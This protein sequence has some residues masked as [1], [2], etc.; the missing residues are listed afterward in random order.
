LNVF[1]EEDGGFKVGTILADNN[2]SL[3]VEAPHGKRSKVKANAV[4]LRF[5]R[6]APAEFLHCAQAV[7]DEVDAGFLWEVAPQAEFDYGTLARDY[8]GREPSPVEAAGLLM[9]LHGSPMHFYKKGKGCYRA[10]PAEALK[11]ALASVERKRQQAATQAAYVEA[12]TRFELPDAFRPRLAELLYEPDRNSVEFKALDAASAATGLSPVHLLD[13]CGAIASSHDY[14]LGRFLREH[15]P[16]GT[17][18]GDGLAWVEPED[19][20]VADV[21]AFSI[22]DATTTEIDDALSVRPLPSGGWRVGIHIAAPALGIPRGGDLDRVAF[23]R[24]S[25]VYMPGRKITMLPDSV[26]D[27]FTLREG[28]DCPVVSLYVYLDDGLAP[29][30]YET[31]I[32]RVPVRANL[33]HD[34]LEA[35]FNEATLASGSLDFPF[36]PELK[37]LWSFALRVEAARGKAPGGVER[38]DYNFYVEGDRVRIV[39]RR[40]GSPVDKLVAEL[41]ILANTRWGRELADANRGGIYRAQSNGRVRMSLVPAP[42]EGLGVEQY[43]WSTSPLRRYVDLVNQ[44]QIVAMA[45]NEPPPYARAG[46]DIAVAMRNFE[47]AYDAYAE[48]QRTMERYWCLRWVVQESAWRQPATVLRES[49]VRLDRIPL[50]ARVPSLPELAP[51]TPVDV[52][53]SNVDLLSIDVDC[54]FVGR[55]ESLAAAAA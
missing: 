11:A 2:T 19:L 39:E 42:H 41:M 45:R 15:F 4:M 7:A 36:G 47:V 30:A 5:E 25:T 52:E 28:R 20:S 17:G 3:Q 9:R 34:V 29:G 27:R 21:S 12:L 24:L 46:D 44:R 43:V 16:R 51:G 6:P 53:L 13:R 55:R 38:P 32:E 23:E 26:I 8:F 1:Y 54:R 10:A 40:R 31:R 49:L 22:D 14:H 48:F 33:R 37:F 35:H 50:V 18:F